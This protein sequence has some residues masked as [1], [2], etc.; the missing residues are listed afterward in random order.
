MNS[1]LNTPCFHICLTLF[2]WLLA[3][4]LQKWTKFT[5]LNPVM[6]SIVVIIIF[7]KATGVSYHDYEGNTS[8]ISFWLAPSVI[9]LGYAIHQQMGAIKSDI[10]RILLA[11]FTGSVVGIVSVVLLAW[12]FGASEL[13]MISLAPK[14]VTTPIAIETSRQMGGVPPLTV[15]FVIVVGVFG[16]LSGPLF[17]KLIGVKGAHAIGLSMGASSH[18]LGTATIGEKGPQY[19]AYGGVGMAITGAITAVIAPWIVAFLLQIL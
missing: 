14:S 3:R 16:A 9:A 10:R 6:V 2:V 13:T 12:F 1:L 18:A 8:F 7:L 15:A 19:S 17:L 5:W 4:E 11:L